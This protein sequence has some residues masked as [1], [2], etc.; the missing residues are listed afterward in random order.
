MT[1]KCVVGSAVGY[2]SNDCSAIA[3][4][5]DN[6]HTIR[7]PTFRLRK[8]IVFW[9]M[10]G[11]CQQSHCSDKQTVVLCTQPCQRQTIEECFVLVMTRD[12][13]RL[14]SCWANC[15]VTFYLFLCMLHSQG[16]ISLFYILFTLFRHFT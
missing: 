7:C 8:K 2:E 11:R 15:Y 5:T 6:A 16:L 3:V 14:R 13:Y 12:C 4:V 10:A 9:I 1:V